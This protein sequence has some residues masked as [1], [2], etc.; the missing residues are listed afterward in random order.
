MTTSDAYTLLR[1]AIATKRQAHFV[2]K[3]HRRETCPHAIGTGPNM[4]EQV[5]VYQFGGSSSSGGSIDRVAD[6]QRWRCLA[7]E[8][9]SQLTIEDGPWHTAANHTRKSTCLKRIDLEVK[10]ASDD[11]L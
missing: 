2:Y 6:E 9:I 3:G 7:L 5:L 8:E 11:D 10:P 1:E 4:N